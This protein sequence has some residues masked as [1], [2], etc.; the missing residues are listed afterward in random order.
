MIGQ[1]ELLLRFD[2]LIEKNKF[3]K[4]C[5]ITGQ[6]GSGKKT[7]VEHIHKQFKD[8]VFSVHGTSVDDIRQMITE[9]NRLSAV[10]HLCL[11]PDADGM[12]VQAKNALLK[13][14]E[15]PP[16]NTYIIMT[17]EDINNTLETIRS[18]ASVYKMES[19]TVAQLIQYAEQRKYKNIDIIK[20]VCETPGEID[21]L[22]SHDVPEFYNFVNKTVDNIAVANGANVFKLTNKLQLK[23]TPEGYDLK[24][25]FKIFIRICV[26]RFNETGDTMYMR[27]VEITSTYLKDL[28]IKGISKQGVVDLWILDIRKEWM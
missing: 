14:T 7:I 5:V 6:A 4:F 23:D 26:E 22:C 17:L 11:I 24:L 18:R 9:C 19:Y 21:K 13:V 15:E 1:Q 12:S 10:R 20:D 16:K 8:V 28:R 3:P 27:G 25:F 2:Q